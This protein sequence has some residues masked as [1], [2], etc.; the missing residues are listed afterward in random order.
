MGF[1]I[2]ALILVIIGIIVA[3][4]FDP[5]SS[6][7]AFVIAGILLL[8]GLFANWGGY[9]E[10]FVS[11]EHELIPLIEDTSIYLIQSDGGTKMCKYKITSE[12][13]IKVEN[14][15]I[16]QISSSVDLEYI[17]EGSKPVLREYISNPKKSKWNGIFAHV[18]EYPVLFVPESYI[19]K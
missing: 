9:E 19:I 14:T 6:A 2:I 10:P 1:F 15:I 8:L 7:P 3:V 5:E 12:H 11:N 16:K 4:C 13:D 18:K 17:E